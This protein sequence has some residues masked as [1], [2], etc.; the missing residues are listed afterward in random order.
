MIP[1][2]NTNLFSFEIPPIQECN[3]VARIIVCSNFKINWFGKV[4]IA[5][6]LLTILLV[7][8]KQR[9]KPERTFY[10]YFYLLLIGLSSHLHKFCTSL[11]ALLAGLHGRDQEF[12]Q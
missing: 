11:S 3:E 6:W 2:F 12:V 5:S 8:R 4:H 7:Y 9:N 1:N 10:D